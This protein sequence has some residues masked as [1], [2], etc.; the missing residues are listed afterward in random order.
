MLEMGAVWRDSRLLKPLLV[1]VAGQIWSTLARDGLIQQVGYRRGSLP[2]PRCVI[3]ALTFLRE[4]FRVLSTRITDHHTSCTIAGHG[5]EAAIA[6][7]PLLVDPPT[8][9]RH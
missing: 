7:Q 8:C 3:I 5:S 1:V 4:G 2:L 6:R 9:L